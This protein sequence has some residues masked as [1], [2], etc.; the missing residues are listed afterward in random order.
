MLTLPTFQS[1]V[2]EVGGG[3]NLRSQAQL[4]PYQAF[5]KAIGGS[6]PVKNLSIGDFVYVL[7]NPHRGRKGQLIKKRGYTQWYIRLVP[8]N[9]REF[10]TV[11]YR[12]KKHLSPCDSNDPVEFVFCECSRDE[13]ENEEFV[14]PYMACYH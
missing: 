6:R 1:A 3:R 9:R 11:I 10:P 12:T 4:M 14:C 5:V 13:R 7:T 2:V 8:K